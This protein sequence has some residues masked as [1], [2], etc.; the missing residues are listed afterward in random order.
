M[1]LITHFKSKDPEATLLSRRRMG[2]DGCNSF[3]SCQ[4]SGTWSPGDLVVRVNDY[5]W[6]MVNDYDSSLI[7]HF[8]GSFYKQWLVTWHG[9]IYL[10]FMVC[11]LPWK[12]NSMVAIIKLT[13]NII[14]IQMSLA[15]IFLHNLA[16]FTRRGAM[17]NSEN[18]NTTWLGN[19]EKYCWENMYF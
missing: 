4:H 1:W 11:G 14:L 7:G 3:C 15:I 2:M 12:K 6:S 13:T 8:N 19:M 5:D 17:L 18:P 10:A 16:H 9:D